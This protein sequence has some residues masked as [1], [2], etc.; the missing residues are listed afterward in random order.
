MDAWATQGTPPPDSRVPT[1][2][3]GTLVDYATWLKQFP[4]IPGV[5][6]LAEPNPLPQPKRVRVLTQEGVDLRHSHL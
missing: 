4:S 3:D 1:R 2:A 5:M 6:A